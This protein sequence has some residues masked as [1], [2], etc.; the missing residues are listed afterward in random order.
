[1]Y[2]GNMSWDEA[3]AAMEEGKKVRNCYFSSDEFFRMD[4]GSIVCENGYSMA[5]W[6]RGEEWQTM[7]WSILAGGT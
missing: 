7:G 5:G 3:K 4:N 1:M 6:Y 2:K